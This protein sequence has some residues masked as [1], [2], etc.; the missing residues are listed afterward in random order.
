[1]TNIPYSLKMQRVVNLH[2]DNELVRPIN[3]YALGYNM[4]IS[5]KH[6]EPILRESE[7]DVSCYSGS[8]FMI[9]NVKTKD[10]TEEKTPLALSCKMECV[11]VSPVQ[12]YNS[13][14][15]KDYLS[16]TAAYITYSN[17]TGFLT[18]IIPNLG[19]Y[20]KIVFPS[21]DPDSFKRK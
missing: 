9:L 18:T 16:S 1:M 3:E 5:Y 19:Q 10:K 13:E 12:G 15:F 21:I 2:I 11:F 8:V 14:D 20:C 4:E 7:S 17:L 6:T